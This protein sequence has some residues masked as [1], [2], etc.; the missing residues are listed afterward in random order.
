MKNTRPEDHAG[1]HE[2]HLFLSQY[3]YPR[4]FSYFYDSTT[5]EIQKQG[6]DVF[7][8]KDG[9]VLQIDEKCSPTYC[10]R[11]I[12]TAKTF[13]VEICSEQG[14]YYN[15]QL[16]GSWFTE[17]KRTSH[18]LFSW[19]SVYTGP[20]KVLPDNKQYP[21]PYILSE[22]IQEI[23]IITQTYET[24]H[25]ILKFRNIDINKV[26]EIAHNMYY[27]QI[28]EYNLGNGY[29]L[30]QNLKRKEKCIVM[31]IPIKDHL[32]YAVSVEKVNRDGI[33][34]IGR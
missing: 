33:I 2:A 12:D 30:K 19:P 16:V 34:N 20:M 4:K 18:F 22:H 27:N 23:T 6:V 14:K 21:D 17:R 15:R 8:F 7:A 9:K 13:M 28:R 25:S 1:E 10:N 31:P 26:I 5:A 24:L 29:W 3:Y 11:T 32:L